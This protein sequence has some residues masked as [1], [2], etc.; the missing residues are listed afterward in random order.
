MG[1]WQVGVWDFLWNF[2]WIFLVELLAGYADSV[3]LR[4][5]KQT[6]DG[7]TWPYLG[8]FSLMHSHYFLLCLRG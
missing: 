4:S 2:S 6:S 5:K 7:A 1:G 3:V 8:L